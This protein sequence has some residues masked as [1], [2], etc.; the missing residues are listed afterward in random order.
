MS[1]VPADSVD[2][3]DPTTQTLR[4]PDG[5]S[6]GYADYGTPAGVPML[7]LHGQPGSRLI[8][9]LLDGAAS[10]VGVRLIAVDRPGIGLS[11]PVDERTHSQFAGD[12]SD[13]LEVLGLGPTPVVAW[14]AGGAYALAWAAA[15]P[16]LVP[17]VS[18][19][20]GVGPG[21]ALDGAW[22]ALK[23]RL[24]VPTGMLRMPAEAWSSTLSRTW[25]KTRD[26]AGDRVELAADV[27]PIL[28]RGFREGVRQGT[29]AARLETRLLGG[30]WDFDPATVRVPVQLWHGK[31]DALVPWSQTRS[32]AAR[33][34]DARSTLLPGEGHVSLLVNHGAEILRAMLRV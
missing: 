10:E 27:A 24:G 25:L 32:L 30:D 2:A 8:G 9:A 26:A 19:L 4:L 15:R 17:L 18:V 12:L 33:I 20:G 34:P 1:V 14:S 3:V 6:L 5:R 21:G 13:A 16:E 23:N 29:A 7:F 22:S 11:D 28:A 31:A